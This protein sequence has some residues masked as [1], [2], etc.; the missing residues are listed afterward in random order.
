MHLTDTSL[1]SIR[2]VIP[3]AEENKTMLDLMLST[4]FYD[5]GVIYNR[6]GVGDSARG[7]IQKKS[8]DF[9]SMISKAN[10]GVLKQIDKF[11]KTFEKIA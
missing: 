10:T 9:T 5:I 2:T 7:I 1:L 6:G 4:R 3:F 11:I 8:S